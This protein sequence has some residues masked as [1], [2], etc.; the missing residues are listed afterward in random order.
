M[1]FAEQ[2]FQTPEQYV[3]IIINEVDNETTE[4]RYENNVR[5]TNS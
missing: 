3:Q 1:S 4:R 2:S 5:T